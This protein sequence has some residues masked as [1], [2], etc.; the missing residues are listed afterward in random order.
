MPAGDRIKG[1]AYMSGLSGSSRRAA[2]GKREK[3]RYVGDGRVA[4]RQEAPSVVQ[5][6]LFWLFLLCFFVLVFVVVP[7]VAKNPKHRVA[8]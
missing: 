2:L 7:H 1:N 6:V 3:Q 8:G 5:V 4:R